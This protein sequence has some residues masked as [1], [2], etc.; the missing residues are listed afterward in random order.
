MRNNTRNSIYTATILVTLLLSPHTMYA[1]AIVNTIS[2]QTHSGGNTTQNGE[3]VKGTTKS[4]VDIVTTV[5][6][7]VVEET[8]QNSSD[9]PIHI[10]RT[11]VVNTSN[12]ARFASSTTQYPT[13]TFITHNTSNESQTEIRA[14][15]TTE[16]LLPIINLTEEPRSIEQT[17]TTE[18]SFP[19][20]HL[21]SMVSKT[22]AYVFSIFF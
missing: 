17:L 9:T 19:F 4:S 3:T 20:T 11:T 7:R 14:S 18:P 12:T 21:I 8:H 13:P 15:A 2:V 1:N 5:D 22:F 16:T 6:G 10:E